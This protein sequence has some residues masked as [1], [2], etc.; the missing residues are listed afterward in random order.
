MK[1]KM[2]MLL[3]TVLLTVFVLAGCAET[4]PA[5]KSDGSADFSGSAV[6]SKETGASMPPSTDNENG[7]DYAE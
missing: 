2:V 1:K 5:Q 6:R 7:S 4:S 3:S